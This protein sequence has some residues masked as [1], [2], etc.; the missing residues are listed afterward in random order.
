[1]KKPFSTGTTWKSWRRWSRNITGT[2]GPKQFVRDHFGMPGAS[3]PV[4]RALRLDITGMLVD[5][6][7]KRV[8]NMT[9][10]WGAR[11]PGALPG[12]RTGGAGGRHAAGNQ[13]VRRRKGDPE[14]SGGTPAPPPDHLPEK[15]HFSVPALKYLRGE[16]LEFARDIL[17]SDRARSRGLFRP[18]YVEKLLAAPEEHITVLG[19]SK[20]WQ[21]ALLE[22]WL[23]EM[24]C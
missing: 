6:P 7:L 22:F 2:T 20:L 1:M 21:L 13:A 4:D 16:Y 12:S 24:G 23:E 5:D 14:E 17:L 8:D 10:S 19:G 11:F 18:A 3:H 15:G 9:M